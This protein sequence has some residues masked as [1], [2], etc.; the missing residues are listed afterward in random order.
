MLRFLLGLS[1]PVVVAL[2]VYALLPRKMHGA[3]LLSPKP[4]NILIVSVCS[5]RHDRVMGDQ[6][7]RLLP[8]VTAW[9][10][11]AIRFENAIG[12]KPWQNHSFDGQEILTR[13]YLTE[14]GYAEVKGRRF[15][16]IAPPAREDGDGNFFF[17]DDDVLHFHEKVNEFK[18]TLYANREKPF[19]AFLHFKYMHYPYADFSNLGVEKLRSIGRDKFLRLARYKARP[20]DFDEKLPLVLLLFNDLGFLAKKFGLPL[21]Y[22]A[23]GVVSNPEYT[24]RWAKTG[25]YHEDLALVKTLYD[26]KLQYFDQY[27]AAALKLFGDEELQQNTVVVFTG[28]HGEAF[29]EHGVLGH[30]VNLYDEMIRFPLLI[31]LPGTSS[32][33]SVQGQVTH[34]LVSQILGELIEGRTDA[35]NFASLAERMAKPAVIS[36][37]C[38]D[39]MRSV[40]MNSKWKYIR[41]LAS[42]KAELYDLEADPGETRNLADSRT[43]VAWLMEEAMI[44]RQDEFSSSSRLQRLIRTC[45]PA[46]E[47]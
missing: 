6:A 10:E 5:L 25:D 44:D 1:L 38:D 27:A 16:T 2:A 28:D 29:M 17:L 14:H 35:Q 26:L 47:D 3:G 40:R 37:T 21:L 24:S 33:A 9:S 34:A 8:Q 32:P 30:S 42:N 23:S 4:P 19:F 12:E 31:K 46:R 45:I 7:A 36:R 11:G 18:E 13:A 15:R 43:D 22:S 41:H 39:S 20:G